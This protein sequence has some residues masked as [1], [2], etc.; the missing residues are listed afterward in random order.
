MQA[1]LNTH[2]ADQPQNRA[3]SRGARPK[4][5]TQMVRGTQEREEQMEISVS[6]QENM[7][8]IQV[9]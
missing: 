1:T 2:R 4:T 5:N 9:G 8:T 3:D 7:K 6:T